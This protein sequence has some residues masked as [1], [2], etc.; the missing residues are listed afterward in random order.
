MSY[1][2]TISDYPSAVFNSMVLPDF[3]QQSQRLRPYEETTVLSGT[4]LLKRERKA[5]VLVEPPVAHEP[6]G[7]ALRFARIVNGLNVL[8]AANNSTTGGLGA[9]FPLLNET[10]EPNHLGALSREEVL[11]RLGR[12]LQRAE[13]QGLSAVLL[14]RYMPPDGRGAALALNAVGVLD[15]FLLA[16]WRGVPEEKVELLQ[17][18]GYLTVSSMRRTFGA[19]PVRL[20]AYNVREVIRE[21]SDR[22]VVTVDLTVTDVPSSLAGILLAADLDEPRTQVSLVDEGVKVSEAITLIRTGENWRAEFK[23]DSGSLGY[24]YSMGEQLLRHKESRLPPLSD[25]NRFVLDLSVKLTILFSSLEKLRFN[26]VRDVVS[27]GKLTNSA[28]SDSLNAIFKRIVTLSKE[29]ASLRS[30]PREALAFSLGASL[31]FAVFADDIRRSAGGGAL[32]EMR[33]TSLKLARALE[34]PPNDQNAINLKFGTS[35]NA[36]NSS[37]LLGVPE[38]ISAISLSLSRRHGPR[39]S[40]IFDSGLEIGRAAL[41]NNPDDSNQAKV[42]VTRLALLKAQLVLTL[43][44]AK[45]DSI[46]QLQSLATRGKPLTQEEEGRIIDVNY[47]FDLNFDEKEMTKPT[48]KPSPSSGRFDGKPSEPPPAKSAPARSSSSGQFDSENAKQHKGSL[49][50]ASVDQPNPA[51]A[52]TNK[53]NSSTQLPVAKKV[54]GKAGFVVSPHDADGRYVDVRFFPQGTK[55]RCPFT[56]KV[57][58]VP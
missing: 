52:S 26:P 31:A 51:T 37:A 42:L 9:V 47:W 4:L 50:K 20:R 35:S 46:N 48:Q 30:L 43:A 16:W 55:A 39:I 44:G 3:L 14:Q 2:A 40:F 23:T 33:G 17:A 34:L 38:D 5:W 19:S 27:L 8:P 45:S 22:I 11:S 6:L 58:L 12:K 13:E 57:F 28:T 25:Q 56:G 15:A 54:P 29:S 10:E 53:S 24:A 21:S 32:T 1:E 18:G 7:I 41:L 49:L 36:D